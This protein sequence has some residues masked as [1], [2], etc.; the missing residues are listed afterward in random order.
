MPNT[1]FADRKKAI[2]YCFANQKGGV[3]KTTLAIQFAYYCS[4]VLRKKTL[5][6]DLDG[7]GNA[8][9]SILEKDDE[10]QPCYD[11]LTDEAQS[12]Q[13]FVK[14]NKVAMN[15]IKCPWDVDLIGSLPN[16]AELIDVTRMN[17]ADV[18]IAPRRVK[19]LKPKYDVIIVDCPPTNSTILFAALSMADYVIAPIGLGYAIVGLNGIA[20]SCYDVQLYREKKTPFMLGAVFNRVRRLSEAKDILDEIKA[21]MPDM[22]FE[23]TLSDRPGVESASYTGT[24]IWRQ[25]YNHVAATEISKFCAEIIEKTKV[26]E[27]TIMKGDD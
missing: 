25:R 18:L 1:L 22:V 5:I 23:T 2:T 15:P 10:G 7:Q 19:D 11:L 21:S 8:T 6:I 14:G 27:E 16:D 20:Q 3:G 9:R 12:K 4:L 24:P 17:I 26:V 13:F